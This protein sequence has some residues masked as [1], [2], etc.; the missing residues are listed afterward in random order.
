LRWAWRPASSIL[1]GRRGSND[2]IL[3]QLINVQRDMTWLTSE[4]ALI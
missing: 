4:P 2:T 1:P 3:M